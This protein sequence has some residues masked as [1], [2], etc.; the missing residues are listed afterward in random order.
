MHGNADRFSFRALL[1]S[2]MFLAAASSARAALNVEFTQT[3]GPLSVGK[4]GEWAVTITNPDPDD[5]TGVELTITLPTD[6]ADAA[7]AYLSVVNPGGGSESGPP[8]H[9]L[10][11]SN[12]A[13]PGGDAISVRFE[14]YPLCNAGTGRL[15]FAGIQPQGLTAASG[16]MVV[17]RPLIA[18]TLLDALGN[19]VTK[20]HL[21]DT[22]IWTLTLDNSG[23][24]D[25]ARGADID[26]TLG[27]NFQFTSIASGSGHQ[28]PATINPGITAT[29]N[30]GPIPSGGQATYTIEAVVAGCD[31]LALVN[32]ASI[33]WGDGTGDCLAQSRQ[34]TSSVALEIQEPGIS[35]TVQN[36]GPIDYCNG[37]KAGITI[38]NTGDGPAENFILRVPAWPREWGV[39]GLTDGVTFQEDAINGGFFFS[40]PAIAPGETLDIAF[41][42]TIKDG[43]CDV[44]SGE[45]LLF[46]PEYTNHCGPVFGTVYTTPVNPAQNWSVGPQDAPTFTV[47]KAGP[48]EALVGDTGLVY[49]ITVTYTG[50][51][52][53]LPYTASIVDDYPDALQTGLADG[54]GFIVTDAGG[55]TDDGEKIT[56]SHTFNNPGDS[57]AYTVIMDAPLD[58]CA[59]FGNYCNIVTVS[60]VPNDCRDCP[61]IIESA[62]TCTYMPDTDGPIIADSSSII[63]SPNPSDVCTE[64]SGDNLQFRTCYTFSS[65]APASWNG[66]IFNNDP[67]AALSFV[68]IDSV[69]VNGTEY[70]NDIAGPLSFPL[71][72][73]G[74]D[75]PS[76]LSKPNSGATVC[77]TYTYSAENTEGEFNNRSWLVVPGNGTE[78]SASPEFNVSNP[79]S[80]EGSRMALI[81]AQGD[82]PA[83]PYLLNTCEETEYSITVNG[84]RSLY[85]AAITLDTQNNYTYVKGSAA[86]IDNPGTGGIVDPVRDASGNLIAAFEPT[87]NGDGTFT[88]DLS[89][90]TP[91]SSGDI[92][93]QG[94]IRFRMRGNCSTEPGPWSARGTFNNRCEKGTLPASRSAVAAS[95]PQ[96]IRDGNPTL[97]LVPYKIYAA[98]PYPVITAYIVNGGSGPLYN[99]AMTVTLDKNT[100]NDLLHWEYSFPEGNDPNSVDAPQGG[101]SATFIYDVIPAGERRTV[102]ITAKLDGCEDLDIDAALTWCD[103]TN[104]CDFREK[105]SLVVLSQSEMIVVEHTAEPV[106]YCGDGSNNAGMTLGALNTGKTDVYG[107]QIIEILP[108]GVTLVD[109]ST[110][111]SHTGGYAATGGNGLD[112]TP[113]VVRELTAD[114]REKI[115]WDFS[116]ALP[117]DGDGDRAMKVG[118][119]IQVAFEV[120]FSGCDAVSDFDGAPN[121]QAEATALFNRPCELSVADPQSASAPNILSIQPADPNVNVVKRARNVTKGTDWLVGEVY[122]D[123][124]DVVEWEITF[125]SNGEVAA[126]NVVIRE[127][128]PGNVILA[129]SGDAGYVAYS[130]TCAACVPEDFFSPAGCA[131]GDMSPNAACTVRFSTKI[132]GCQS[133]PTT[134]TADAT[135]GC[136]DGPAMETQAAAGRIRTTPDFSS[137][138]ATLAHDNWTTCGGQVT[139]TL[140][141]TGGTAALDT[142]AHRIAYTPPAGYVFDACEPVQALNT[143]ANVIHASFACTPQEQNG[144]LLWNSDNIDFVAPGETIVISFRLKM[145]AAS[146]CDTSPANDGNDLDISV[147]DGTHSVQ[148]DFMDSCNASHSES[149]SQPI[150]PGQPDIDIQVTPPEQVAAEG[151]TA[152]WAVTL[153][154]EGDAPAYNITLTDALGDGFSNIADNQGGVFIGNNGVW[155][156]P[157]PINPGQTWTVNISATA[158]EGALTHHA[159][160]DGMCEDQA[161]TDTCTYTYDESDSYVAGFALAKTVDKSSVNVGELLTYTITAGFANTDEFRN[162]VITDTPPAGTT[163]VGAVQNG[164]DFTVDPAS[165]GGALTW[166]LGS[167]NGPKA[168]SYRVR[169]RINDETNNVSGTV[170]TNSAAA[171]FDIRYADGHVSSFLPPSVEVSAAVTDPKIDLVRKTITPDT[172]LQAGD[173]V[174]ITLEIQNTGDGPAYNIRLVDL[175]NDTDNDGDVDGSDAVVYACPGGI[176]R[177]D[178]VANFSFIVADEDNDPSGTPNDCQVVYTIDDDTALPAGESRIFSF[179][180]V[181]ADSAVSGSSYTNRATADAWSMKPGDPESGNEAYNRETVDTAS[182]QLQT[183]GISGP[184]KSIIGTSETFTENAAVAVGEVV[185]YRIPFSFPAGLTKAVTIADEIPDGLG[186][187]S[188]SARLD[189]DNAGLAS[190]ANPGNINANLPGNSVDVILDT[191]TAGEVSLALGDVQNNSGASAQFILALA[192]VT[193]NTALNAAGA[194]LT[195]YGRIDWQTVSGSNQSTAGNPVTVTVA[196]PTPG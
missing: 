171:S 56:W 66:M 136:C 46:L 53:A 38:E 106:E 151:D 34:Q 71:D 82:P 7:K 84:S 150:N 184:Q 134:S 98:T 191:D 74:L 116:D 128:L 161:G 165:G 91:D 182:D 43:S 112:N 37:S 89:G 24:G 54:K 33:N 180:A 155:T 4:P 113:G 12:L 190:A 118:S 88:W 2:L 130:S 80:I 133:P 168:F 139:I 76:G 39:S 67:E 154:N 143:P 21:G 35:L 149:D 90:K 137:G 193:K 73:S 196:E 135:Y 183:S 173:T 29:W 81:A 15:L 3:P 19:S 160:V 86:F 48:A 123:T 122:A 125:T 17:N 121:H 111:V 179:T 51:A 162:V 120:E 94:T 129:D 164:G 79:F 131:I 69:T 78:C 178:A 148:F 25:V 145:D 107:A 60:A 58:E 72:L 6:P 126:K 47:T 108:A 23:S 163:Y 99:A 5:V 64:P 146:Y 45:T 9:A 103:N 8:V 77:V 194:D 159:V 65:G 105:S 167:F 85:D 42:V 55:G 195:D 49:Q 28:L 102:E 62:E 13:I 115:T 75:T 176:S 92:L 63:L 27:S 147:P 187:I 31:R 87:D 11:W 153:T 124:G 141:N 119:R 109:S 101:H 32:E 93:P 185:R 10:T 96:Y 169:V 30:S 166:T 140:D 142:T 170:L 95:E 192:C 158:G 104:Y 20:G 110:T 83:H 16:P 127:T 70:K 57:A 177:T 59:A 36:P 1:V 174:T 41:D 97:H 132:T 61:G 188:G 157:G 44:T 156:I 144:Q 26:F 152:A 50:P 117:K 68:A 186:Y 175:L 22:V 114:G 138:A 100:E 52:S 40:I 14:A 18:V 172:A 189:R 181:L